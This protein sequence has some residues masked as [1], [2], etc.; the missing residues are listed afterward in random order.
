MSTSDYLSIYFRLFDGYNTSEPLFF[1]Y[2]LPS[3]ELIEFDVVSPLFFIVLFSSPRNMTFLISISSDFESVGI[4]YRYWNFTWSQSDWCDLEI[5]VPGKTRCYPVTL[6]AAPWGGTPGNRMLD[7]R[8]I[9]G[10]GV[11]MPEHTFNL[12][13][14]SL[15][16]GLSFNSFTTFGTFP[17]DAPPATNF[18]ITVTRPGREFLPFICEVACFFR[19]AC[20]NSVE[21]QPGDTRDSHS[22]RLV[23]GGR[24]YCWNPL[25]LFL[26]F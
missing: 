26:S 14:P 22:Y 5:A 19:G 11:S 10:S 18:S 13:T 15:E 2:G 7:L 4:Q 12:V 25:H 20:G 1:G 3:H 21:Y 23:G 9:A 16:V 17:A 8:A 24:P 6:P